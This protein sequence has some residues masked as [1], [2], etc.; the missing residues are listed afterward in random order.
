MHE[1]GALVSR[2][3]A[4]NRDMCPVPK[5]VHASG[6]GG[7]FLH[8]PPGIPEMNR[9]DGE[10]LQQPRASIRLSVCLCGRGGKIFRATCQRSNLFASDDTD[11]DS[12]SISEQGEPNELLAANERFMMKQNHMSYLIKKDNI[13]LQPLINIPFRQ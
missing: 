5:R 2:A 13:K 9:R 3:Y 8:N 4:K 7:I 12:N 10:P 11:N 6:T 1:V